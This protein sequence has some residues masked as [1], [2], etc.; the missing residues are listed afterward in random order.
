VIPK[1]RAA[2]QSTVFDVDSPFY[3]SDLDNGVC[4]L[5]EDQE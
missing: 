4:A 2:V 3:Y 5:N 1:M